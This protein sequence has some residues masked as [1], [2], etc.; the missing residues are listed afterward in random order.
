MRHTGCE[1]LTT[2]STATRK[3]GARRQRGRY[4]IKDMTE[5]KTELERLYAR[6]LIGGAA[7]FVFGFLLGML[8]NPPFTGMTETSSDVQGLVYFSWFGIG[9]AGGILGSVAGL[10]NLRG[11]R[12]EKRK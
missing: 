3:S 11:L 4:T 2:G 12:R 10:V 7:G 1:R 6:I 8:I 9:A 5:D